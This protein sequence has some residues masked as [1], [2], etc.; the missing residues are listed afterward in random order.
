MFGNYKMAV[1]IIR[2]GEEI[3][4]PY[5]QAVLK[6]IANEYSSLRSKPYK[7]LRSHQGP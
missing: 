6:L 7:I 1:R 5:L 4:V 2:L 3:A